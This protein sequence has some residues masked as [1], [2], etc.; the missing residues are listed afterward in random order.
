MF[1]FILINQ[2]V[3]GSNNCS[4]HGNMIRRTN[5]VRVIPVTILIRTNNYLD[6]QLRTIQRLVQAMDYS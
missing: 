4:N 3:P 6:E 5:I 1:T 2:T